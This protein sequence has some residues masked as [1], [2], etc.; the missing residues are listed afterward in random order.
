VNGVLGNDH[1]HDEDM[2]AADAA[3]LD[4]VESSFAGQTSSGLATST[5]ARGN[6]TGGTGS[7]GAD[8]GVGGVN[9]NAAAVE[10]AGGKRKM[11]ITCKSSLIAQR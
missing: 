2:D 5:G 6:G 11:R 8:G 10:P 9:G 7:G 3:A 1:D 4:A